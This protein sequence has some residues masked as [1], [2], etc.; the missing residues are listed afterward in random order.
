MIG[1]FSQVT[2]CHFLKLEM[3]PLNPCP[4][5][6]ACI[7]GINFP[8]SK[9]SILQTCI[10]PKY[11]TGIIPGE[12]W[13]VETSCQVLLFFHMA[14]TPRFENFWDCFPLKFVQ[15]CLH[16]CTNSGHEGILQ[17]ILTNSAFVYIVELAGR[18]RTEFFLDEAYTSKPRVH[19]VLQ[20]LEKPL[21]R[22]R[23]REL[24]PHRLGHQAL[25]TTS[26]C[27]VKAVSWGCSH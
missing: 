17:I 2:L 16:S 1:C 9:W 25:S 18:T 23:L 7:C 6:I 26:L 19:R 11:F 15:A 14:P 10:F 13:L 5:V 3:L 8:C 22:L 21:E 24:R 12:P 27:S 20:G 4:M